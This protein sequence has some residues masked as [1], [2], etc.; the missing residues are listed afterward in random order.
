MAK[1]APTE[2]TVLVRVVDR[3]T[4][5]Q[6]MYDEGLTFREIAKEFGISKQRVSH[7]IGP[8]RKKAH[9]GGA[10]KSLMLEERT[11][12]FKRIQ[13]GESML[14]EEAE[15]IGVTAKTLYQY[16]VDHKMLLPTK[17]TLSPKHGTTYRYGRGCHCEKCKQAV[18]DRRQRRKGKE[19]PRHGTISGYV[20]YGCLCDECRAAGSANNRANREAR[21]RREAGQDVEQG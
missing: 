1:V 16:L 11:A 5:M 15:R 3:N 17:R 8:Q 12:A 21:L 18:R 2:E 7:L 19:P 20:N 9:Y 14:A 13:A 6:S 4:V 10:R